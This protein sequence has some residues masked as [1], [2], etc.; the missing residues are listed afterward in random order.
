MLARAAV[1][2]RAKGRAGALA[3]HHR[4]FLRHLQLLRAARVEVGHAPSVLAVPAPSRCPHAQ[5][6][7]V[8]VHEAHVVEVL[9]LPDGELRQ[10]DRR[11]TAA[12]AFERAAA[13]SGGALADSGVVEV[14]TRSGPEAAR[15]TRRCRQLDCASWWQCEAAV[16][17]DGGA[18]AGESS[19]PDC[20]ATAV[21]ERENRRC[22]N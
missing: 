6:H 18:I 17:E 3:R 21:Y 9:P 15:P 22:S 2:G 8:P 5:P 13:V 16:A 14:A 1:L 20:V 11:R 10:A 12:G 4:A 19:R 7:V